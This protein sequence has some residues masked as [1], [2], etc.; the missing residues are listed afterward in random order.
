MFFVDKIKK[1]PQCV[2]FRCRSLHIFSSLKKVVLSYNLQ[3]KLL[4]Q[5]L[6]HGEICEDTWKDKEDECLP[7]IKNDELSTAFNYAKYTKGM[8]KKNKFW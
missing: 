3:P 1:I 8:E 7:Y 6:A 5:E 4:E 2:L